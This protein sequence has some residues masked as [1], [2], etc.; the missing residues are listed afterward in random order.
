[1]HVEMRKITD[2]QPY[3]NNPRRDDQAVEA[4]ARSI[5]EFGFR[6]P[7]VVDEAGTI[8]VG[9]TRYKAAVRLG[10]KKVPVHVAKGLTAAQIKDRLMS[11]GDAVSALAGKT[12]SGRRLNIFKA[13]SASAPA[14]PPPPAPGNLAAAAGNAQISLSWTSSSGATTRSGPGPGRKTAGS[15]CRLR[16]LRASSPAPGRHRGPA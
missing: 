10:L 6:Q 12:V 11:N 7:I 13:L 4:V 2:I 9:N 3:A 14:N 5:A 1:M 15:G 8:I 16:K